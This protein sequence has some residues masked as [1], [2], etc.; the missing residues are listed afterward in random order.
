M[1]TPKLYTPDVKIDK[2]EGQRAKESLVERIATPEE[3]AEIIAKYGPPK[4]KLKD[5]ARGFKRKG[6]A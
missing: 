5:R 1:T 4:A 3:L 2:T 6:S